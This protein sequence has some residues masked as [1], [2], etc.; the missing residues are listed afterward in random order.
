MA[1]AG[2]VGQSRFQPPNSVTPNGSRPIGPVTAGVAVG[3]LVGAGIA[4]LVAPRDGADVRRALR[5]RLRRVGHRS[6][7]AW[8][9]LRDE[10]RR[11][12]IRMRRARDQRR[13][14]RELVD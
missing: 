1:Y 11:A 3:L 8:L 12:A 9:D 13:A 2:K 4:L 5:R 6:Q 14:D 10:L 7:D